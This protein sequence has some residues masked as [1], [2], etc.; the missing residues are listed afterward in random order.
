MLHI[1]ALPSP[2]LSQ[3]SRLYYNKA[4][5]ILIKKKKISYLFLAVFYDKWL[6][7]V[8]CRAVCVKPQFK[9]YCE[10]RWLLQD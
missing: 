9:Q 4:V 2:I 3:I 6:P 5:N 8:R 10:Q 1:I 7:L